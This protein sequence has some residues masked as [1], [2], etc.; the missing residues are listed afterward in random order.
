MEVKSIKTIN[1]YGL[2]IKYKLE[3]EREIQ[4]KEISPVQ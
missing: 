3:F 2:R 4:Y 1:L